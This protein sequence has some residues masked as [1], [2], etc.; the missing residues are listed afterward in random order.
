MAEASRIFADRIDRLKAE[1]AA[2]GLDALMLTLG[3]DMPWL[4]GYAP[5]PLERIT[6]CVVLRDGDPV[7]VIPRLEAPRFSGYPEVELLPWSDSTDP[8]DLLVKTLPRDSVVGVGDRTWAYWLM[9]VM[10]RRPDIEFV[11]GSEAVTALRRTKDESEVDLLRKAAVAADKVAEL[12]TSGVIALAGRTEVEV[13]REIGSALI[14]FGHSRVNFAIVASGP[15]AASPHHE[16]GSRVIE[17]GDVVVCD[18]GGTFPWLGET[19]YC[20][21]I[22]RTF[23]VGGVVDPH[24]EDLYRVLREAQDHAVRSV[25]PGMAGSEADACAR[26]VISEAGFGEEFLHRLGHGIGLEEHEEPY[27]SPGS[28]TVLKVGDCFSIEPGIYF[29]G[30]YGARIEDIVVLRDS[31][32][33]R[34]NLA[35][36]DLVFVEG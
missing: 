35:S 22:T 5:M 4:I 29:Q 30:R 11:P 33:E 6:A 1:M 26:D 27:L 31:G 7:L 8:Y 28:A 23:A 12:I 19:G 24:F 20:S 9:Q 21:D 14:E 17:H 3:A 16:P 13:S 36:R 32:C 34:L 2:R 25:V 15:N 10:K 18:F